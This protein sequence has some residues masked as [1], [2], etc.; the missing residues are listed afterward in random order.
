METFSF[1]ERKEKSFVL[2]STWDSGVAALSGTWKC[3][4][5]VHTWNPTSA[6]GIGKSEGNKSGFQINLHQEFLS[7]GSVFVCSLLC[8][9]D[10]WAHGKRK[11]SLELGKS[12]IHE[13]I[14]IMFGI[15]SIVLIKRNC[16]YVKNFFLSFLCRANSSGLTSMSLVTL[17][18]PTLR[19]VSF[20]CH[21]LESAAS[22]LCFAFNPRIDWNAVKGC[23]TWTFLWQHP[24]H[25]LF[26]NKR[27][28]ITD[29]AASSCSEILNSQIPLWNLQGFQT[30]LKPR[31]CLKG[32]PCKMCLL[33]EHFWKC[34]EIFLRRSW[35]S[36]WCQ[37]S[38]C[39]RDR[40]GPP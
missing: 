33:W 24:S 32:K 6:R 1:W 15:D 28:N 38:A 30:A 8:W 21:I 35:A 3:C 4:R 25:P 18:G 23:H 13:C 7:L 11:V 17:L 20:S 26:Q 27:S 12:S 2:G 34:P 29:S 10:G 39:S 9:N 19:P 37:S 5:N 14:W 16:N 36:V 22:L 31:V 40:A